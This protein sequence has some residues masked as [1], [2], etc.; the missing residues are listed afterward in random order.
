M[1]ALWRRLPV[2]VRA[3]LTGGLVATL[4]TLPWALLVSLNIRYGSA[5]PW[6]VPPTALY[7]WLFWRYVRGAWWPRSTAE[8][9]RTLA[10]ANPVPDEMWGLAIFAGLLGLVVV[11]L[12][13][14][15]MSRMVT[16]PQQQDIDPSKYPVLTVFLWVVMSAAVAGI[17]EET[18][19]R[20]YLQGAIE[21]RHG[22]VIAILVTGIL[23]G[24]LHFTHPEV[25][26]ALMPFYLAVAAVYGTLAYL[27]NSIWPSMVLH[28]GGNVFAAFDLFARG[29]SEWQGLGPPAKL[30]W[31]T[32]AD[33]AFWI[34]IGATLVAGAAAVWAYLMLARLRRAPT[35]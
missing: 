7:L 8:T 19:F 32:G 26:L 3:A 5:V 2:I 4:G 18:A 6:A 21:R 24:F 20:G 33:A 9:R 31:E 15:V 16:V 23:F 35:G 28:G 13:Q 10:R 22:P 17:V 25:T 30:V 34:S 27:T 11:L 1:I 14:T 12:L 29:H